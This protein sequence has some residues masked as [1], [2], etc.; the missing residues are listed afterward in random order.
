VSHIYSAVPASEDADD[1]TASKRSY[2][3]KRLIIMGVS[4]LALLSAVAAIG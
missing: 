2:S 3:R 1:I 4:T